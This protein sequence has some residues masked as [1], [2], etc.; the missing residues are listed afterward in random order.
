MEGP[1]RWSRYLRR[2]RSELGDPSP[3]ISGFPSQTS[4][5]RYPS[6]F[7]QREIRSVRIFGSKSVSG[8]YIWTISFEPPELQTDSLDTTF[9]SL[10]PSPPPS[11]PF[12]PSSLTA[13]GSAQH[14]TCSSRS[15]SHSTGPFRNIP[16]TDAPARTI[17][18]LFPSTLS[19]V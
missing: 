15:P 12:T 19:S 4:I 2:T 18:I 16:H 11:L 9:P 7:D 3:S 5:V 8:L 13:L 17:T 10:L 14:P 1:R 6:R